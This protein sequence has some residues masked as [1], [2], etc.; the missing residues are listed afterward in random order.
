MPRLLD[1]SELKYLRSRIANLETELAFQKIVTIN[2]NKISS[3]FSDLNSLLLSPSQ[4][5][6]SRN[7]KLC[8]GGSDGGYAISANSDFC[9]VWITAGLGSHIDFEL[10]LAAQGCFVL[11]ADLNIGKF[12]RLGR[13][14]VLKNQYWGKKD[15]HIELTLESLVHAA[16]IADN[17]DWG[18]KFD[19]EGN[20]WDVLDQIQ[21]L[22]FPPSFITC[23]LHGLVPSHQ[24]FETMGAKIE[25]LSLLARY[26]IPVFIKGNNYSA[27]IVFKD[28][29]IY[30]VIE[31]SWVRKDKL[32]KFLISSSTDPANLIFPN[33]SK[34]SLFKVGQITRNYPL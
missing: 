11:G 3:Y 18:L 19:I 31:M 23:E 21:K 7:L 26:Y 4:T 16:R 30:D 25:A 10:E 1:F 12:R 2:E 34:K 17:I 29:S 5:D 28:F 15:S 14:V 9:K 20:E 32:E 24:N 8:G 6:Y 27:H 22:E 13:N 33:D